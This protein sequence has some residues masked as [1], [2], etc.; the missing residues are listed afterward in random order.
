M[1]GRGAN[2][3]RF[4]YECNEI[5]GLGVAIFVEALRKNRIDCLISLTFDP[6]KPIVRSNFHPRH[7]GFRICAA[8]VR[9][10]GEAGGTNIGLGVALP[11][12][13]S[14]RPSKAQSRNPERRNWTREQDYRERKTTKKHN[15]NSGF[16]PSKYLHPIT[17][18]PLT[19]PP[20]S[21]N[22]EG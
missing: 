9:N 8:L 16:V 17:I 3:F 2:N 15:Y 20:F 22:G 6:R 7:S 14:F 13:P 18:C 1:D 21:A 10:D 4:F 19:Q 12:D 11:C 5:N